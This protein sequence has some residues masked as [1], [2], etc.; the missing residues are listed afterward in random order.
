MD[1]G[2]ATF[3]DFA[4]AAQASLALDA[5]SDVVSWIASCVHET[6]DSFNL[7]EL[8]RQLTDVWQLDSSSDPGRKALPL[9][10]AALLR[11]E[12]GALSLS[13]GDAKEDSGS[14]EFSDQAFRNLI[15]PESIDMLLWYLAGLE[16]TSSRIVHIYALDGRQPATGLIVRDSDLTPNWGEQQYLLT[17][18]S[19]ISPSAN[20]ASMPGWPAA[21]VNFEGQPPIPMGSIVFWSPPTELDVTV[22]T[23]SIPV[24]T[25]RIPPP[26]AWVPPIADG[27]NCA[28]VVSRSSGPRALSMSSCL[29]LDHDATHIHLRASA[30]PMIPGSPVFNHQWEPIGLFRGQ[31]DR[32][33]KL[34]DKV[35]TYRAGEVTW[36]GAI[37][38]AIG[39]ASSPGPTNAVP[40]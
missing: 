17:V 39:D 15:G 29:V 3:W 37:R 12:G 40:R 13:A 31:D 24:F 1:D 10:R 2:D 28:Y 6:S 27:R 21:T 38:D 9:L 18:G 23:L 33:R 20:A 30:E 34:N 25:P 22:A 26:P 19:V 4:A 7:A 14:L 5:P 36:L 8:L 16:S 11:Q 32:L 35:G